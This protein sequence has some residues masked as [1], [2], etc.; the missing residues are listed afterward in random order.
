M[1]QLETMLR[2]WRHLVARTVVGE[3][4]CGTPDRTGTVWARRGNTLCQAAN[5][6]WLD[7]AM[8]NDNICAIIVDD[9]IAV[10]DDTAGKTLIFSPQAGELFLRLHVAGLH[11]DGSEEQPP[12][13]HPYARVHP[14]ATLS[15]DITVGAGVCIGAN[16]TVFGPTVIGDETIIDANAVI[17]AD[18]LFA[19][20]LDGRLV[21]IPHYG[22]VR[23][24][25]GCRIHAGAVIVRSTF[26]EEWT[27]IDDEARIGVMT[28]VG[29]DAQVGAGT[30]VSSNAVIAGRARIGKECW[31]GASATIANGISVGDRAE[32]KVGA[33]VIADVAVKAVVSGNFAIDHRRNLLDHA[34]RARGA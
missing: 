23:I 30:I 21:D 8:S 34:R 4:G 19:K 27:L 7:I 5:R 2:P 18:G 32:V 14:S 24:G 25:R 13:L 3:A 31:I 17:G 20:R 28:N 1:E 33:V 9:R 10:P 26:F 22:G 29:H 12:R 16:A 6:A 11:V 15:G